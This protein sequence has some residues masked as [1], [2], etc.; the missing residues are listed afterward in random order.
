MDLR[1]VFGAWGVEQPVHV[2]QKNAEGIQNYIAEVAEFSAERVALKSTDEH[3]PFVLLLANE[4]NK[5]ALQLDPGPG[6]V[7]SYLKGENLTGATMPLPPAP[8]ALAVGGEMTLS[9]NTLFV[10]VNG[11]AEFARTFQMELQS[12]I[13]ISSNHLAPQ[14]YTLTGL[15]RK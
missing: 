13:T 6:I 10:K 7:P 5:F 4:G 15:L 2:Q 11:R 14:H 8:V 12:Y 3:N 9:S 1:T